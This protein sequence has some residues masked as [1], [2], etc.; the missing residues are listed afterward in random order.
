MAC[1]KWF[2][3]TTKENIQTCCAELFI[4]KNFINLL[5]HFTVISMSVCDIMSVEG[6]DT[7]C[8]L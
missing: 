1:N 3:H 4:C 8:K 7:M 2:P 6:R 5:Q